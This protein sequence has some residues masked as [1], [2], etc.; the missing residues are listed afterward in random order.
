MSIKALI[1]DVD[2]TIADT[3]ETHRQSFNAAFLE[4]GLRWEWSRDEYAELLRTSG[5]KE[6]IAVYIESLELGLQETA[7]LKRMVPLIHDS[8]TRIYAELIA[9]GRAPLRPGIARLIGEARAA[10]VRLGIASTTTAANISALIGAQFGAAAWSWFEALAC[11]DLVANKK[12]EPDIY[13][14]ALGMLRLPAQGC[15][16][17]EDSV[18]GLRSAKA[19]GLYTVVTPT[20]WSEGQDFSSADLL[21]GSLGDADAPLAG[22]DAERAGGP[23]LALDRLQRLHAAALRPTA[24]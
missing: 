4:H 3:E 18:N 21:L 9:D 8:K 2:G 16:A 11:G 14:R 5:G 1:F 12:P 22:G 24:A 10:G 23:Y 7:Q 20:A 17:F 13:I 15:V 19:A 6:R